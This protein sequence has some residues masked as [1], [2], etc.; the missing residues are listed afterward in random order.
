MQRIGF[1][2][3]SGVE[4]LDLVGPWEMATMWR[5]YANGPDCIMVGQSTT[6]IKCAKGMSLA[7]EFDFKTCPA[8]DMLVVPGGFAAFD[9]MNNDKLISFIQST[10]KDAQH[11]MSVCSGSF[12]LL[13][14]GLLTGKKATTHWKAIGPLGDA[15]VEVVQERYVRD[16]N[17][18]TS[19]GVSAGI[20]LMLHF[21]AET[22]GRE[23]ADIVQFNAEYYPENTIYGNSHKTDG[24][25]AY[26]SRLRADKE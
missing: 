19:G 12:L 11:M 9:E 7:A 6:P 13:K 10:A 3:Y 18:W 25:P 22:A 17:I 23:A 15:G 2:T 16:G 20:D 24:N 5:T 1:L 26:M 14:A 21:I 8:L 4:E